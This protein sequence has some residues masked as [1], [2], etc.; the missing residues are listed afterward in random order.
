MLQPVCTL[1]LPCQ[2]PSQPVC[3][4]ACVPTHPPARRPAPHHPCHPPLLATL[5]DPAARPS[6][7]ELLQHSWI[8]YNRRTLKSSW[9]RTRGLKAR[10][11]AGA[12]GAAGA[13][14]GPLAGALPPCHAVAA[15][16]PRRG[17]WPRRRHYWSPCLAAMLPMPIHLPYDCPLVPSPA[18]GYTS[19]STVVERILQS[20]ADSEAGSTSSSASGLGFGGADSLTPLEHQQSATATAVPGGM[21]AG[22]SVVSALAAGRRG[23]VDAG[24]SS[25]GGSSPAAA[26]GAQHSVFSV[27]AAGAAAAGGPA[28][29]RGTANGAGGG[30]KLPAPP[31]FAAAE[32]AEGGSPPAALHRLWSGSTAGAMQQQGQAGQQL[33]QQLTAEGDPTGLLLL[34]QLERTASS[35][36]ASS[37]GNGAGSGGGGSSGA[38]KQPALSRVAEDVAAVEASAH[39]RHEVAEVCVGAVVL[40]PLVGTCTCT[41]CP[42]LVA[43]QGLASWLAADSSCY[44]CYHCT[45]AAPH[46]VPHVLQV[47]RQVAGMRII[48]TTA[49]ERSFV[50][51]AAATASAR[52][53]LG[54]L[55]RDPQAGAALVPACPRPGAGWPAGC[56]GLRVALTTVQVLPCQPDAWHVT[57][58]PHCLPASSCCVQLRAA[59]LAA[60]G[61]SALRELLDNPSDRV[62]CACLP[63]CLQAECLH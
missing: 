5:Q 15:G 18:E 19:V 3:P 63:T 21:A 44:C 42:G 12:G 23:G 24:A 13:A 47:K 56:C 9:S 54:P 7:R 16:L 49:G 60:D 4:T 48:T 41:C 52:A 33:G 31:A 37:S 45:A 17:R 40:S 62:G 28:G 51:E 25:S 11:L 1:V 26:G 36:G 22:M 30:A 38:S 8:T 53:L 35:S 6:A 2:L 27:A 29:G 59:F 10:G 20:T 55:A 50:Q 39:S 14:G 43:A 34:Q 32:P 58:N 46:C 61:A 57:V